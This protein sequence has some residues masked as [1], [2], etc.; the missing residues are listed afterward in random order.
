MIDKKVDAQASHSACG[1]R[2]G[3]ELPPR[4]TVSQWA[5]AHRGIAAGTGPEPGRWRTDRAP[6][7]REP[8][9]A[10]NDPDVEIVVLKWSSQVGKTEVLMNVAGYFIDQDP[11]PQLFVLPDLGIADSFS[12]SRFS[13]TI[14]ATPRLLERI[15][16]HSSRSSSTTILEKN[17]PG[18]DI[19]FAGANSP[20]SLA[21]RPR[22]VVLFDEIDKYKAAIGNDGDPIKQGFQ[23][24]QN[25]WN[26][27]KGLASTPTELNLSAIDEWF[28]RSDQRYFDV[29][30]DACGVFHF[31][32]WENVVWDKGKPATAR[33]RCPHCED[34]LDQAQIYRMVRHGHWKARAPFNGTAGFHVW[35]IYSPW[36]TMADLVVEWEDSEGKPTEEQTFI[37]LKVGR[38]YNPTREAS[39][40]ADELLAR[41]ED[42]GPAADGA[43][44]VPPGVLLVTAFVDVQS[45][46]FE[47]TFLG[48]GEGDEKWVLDHVIHY[49]DPTDPAAFVRL[50]VERLQRTFKH[51]SVKDELR[52]EAVAFDAGNWTQIV[53]E[54]V[55]EQRAGF[56]PY[57]AT[58]GMGGWGRPLILE[59]RE[60]FSRGAR[61]HILGVDDGK[62]TVYK[63]VATRPNPE[64][65]E[66]HYRVHFPRHLEKTYF[67][68]LLGEVVKFE[69]VAGRPVPKWKPKPGVRNE[70]LDCFVGA[71]AARYT[72]SVDYAARRAAADGRQ[73]KIDGA[74]IAGL[75]NS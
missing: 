54:F 17:Y 45:N 16:S 2:L 67:E 75:F 27:K 70:A 3:L 29:P 44:A 25:F 14:N 51:P 71:M 69:I 73:T 5:D 10:F 24:T 8:M 39:T 38:A 9:D 18:G 19:V 48:W 42:Y 23:R 46:R 41:R 11:S 28:K 53:M 68:Q 52:V 31:L 13:P 65:G 62:A 74:V 50:D 66:G 22:R 47:V 7:T 61:L 72:L 1:W 58:K 21:S 32:E 4:L 43:Y 60:K 30:C 55:R 33:Y 6:W 63:E 64:T 37:N 57:Y 36:V 59:S 34:L 20:A 49:G 40:T 15:G 26:R 12:R 56:R 35:A